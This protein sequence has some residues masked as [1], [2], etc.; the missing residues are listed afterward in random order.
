MPRTWRT[1]ALLLAVVLAGA[2]RG[3]AAEA[4]HAVIVSV[5]GLMPA[6]YLRADELGLRIPTLRRLM[7]QGAFGRVTGVLPTVTYPSHTTL[8]TGVPPRLHGIA[9][10]TVF[11]PEGRSN[12]AWMWYAASVRVPSLVSAARARGL[13]TAA[14]S[15]PVSVGLA[16]D[17]NLPEFLRSGSDHPAD[18]ALL[19][20]LSTPPG[21]LAD[22]AR[23]RGKAL[24]YPF[25]D[26]DRTDVAVHILRTQRPH[27]LL[28]H[29]FDLDHQE[30]EN[31][32]L[33][34]RARQ[35]VEEADA[36]VARVLKAVEDSGLAPTTLFAV[37]SDHGFLAV[38]QSVKPNVRLREAGLV[39]VNEKGKVTAWTAWFHSDTGSAALRLKD[40]GD[41]ATL[42][43]VRAL[44]A[45][46][47]GRAGS[48]IA[49]ILEARDVER[50]GGDGQTLL[51]L[52]AESGFSF[53]SSI[54][55]PYLGP[56]SNKGVHG[57]GP[58]REE[59]QAALLVVGPG[60]K[61]R[62]L[63]LVPMTGIGPAVARFLGLELS[64][65]AGRPLD[66]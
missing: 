8:I 1:A 26:D 9:S 32:P 35:A 36:R 38:S 37:V 29:I 62:D 57:Y 14:V 22:V 19:E 46:D 2:G 49:R 44:F 65:E 60:V 28:L 63:G 66:W 31:G 64:A 5:D 56:S 15:W 51:A 6:Y 18:L 59:L 54:E 25:D 42:E 50:M 17:F 47:A 13:R 23:A 53:S 61:P 48:G 34:P 20:A 33:T 52:D 40:A 39:T 10:N 30:H 41:T 21:L 58:D 24:T 45:A 12:G 4:R 16:A 55:G 43:K 7:A 11:D 27:L 3:A